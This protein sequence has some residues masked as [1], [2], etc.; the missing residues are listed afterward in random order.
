MRFQKSHFL[1]QNSKIQ[2]QTVFGRHLG[3]MSCVN[4]N[5]ERASKSTAS[6]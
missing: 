6:K 1:Q 5:V 2:H 4:E 3:S